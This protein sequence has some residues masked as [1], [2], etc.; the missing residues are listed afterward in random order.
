M[1]SVLVMK[2][3]TWRVSLFSNEKHNIF[4]S[5]ADNFGGQ[6]RAAQIVSLVSAPLKDIVVKYNRDGQYK[7][8]AAKLYSYSPTKEQKQD[9]TERMSAEYWVS[10][11]A[12]PTR[13]AHA[14]EK[15]YNVPFVDGMPLAFLA[16]SPNGFRGQLL[17]TQFFKAHDFPADTFNVPTGYRSSKTV[18][19]YWNTAVGTEQGSAGLLEMISPKK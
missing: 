19:Q 5:E 1:N 4:E 18:L 12:M 10:K 11:I 14:V 6:L 2:A 16:A 3:P 8:I 17:T 9:G 15:L 7:G 13:A